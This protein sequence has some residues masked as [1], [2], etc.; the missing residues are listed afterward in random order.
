MLLTN[1]VVI[2]ERSM[3]PSASVVGARRD[4]EDYRDKQ[5]PPDADA[6]RKELR[7]GDIITALKPRRRLKSTG[8]TPARRSVDLLVEY[9]CSRTMPPSGPSR[10]HHGRRPR[11]T[12]GAAPQCGNHVRRSGSRQ[13]HRAALLPSIRQSRQRSGYRTSPTALNSSDRR[14]PALRAIKRRAH[15]ARHRRS[16]PEAALTSQTPSRLNPD[17]RGG[18]AVQTLDVAQQ[19]RRLAPSKGAPPSQ[20]DA[21]V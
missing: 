16:W 12:A 3:M 19:N 7:R 11:Q 10:T 4:L 6:W 1:P 9:R 20:H 18:S 2:S 13:R 8:N 21:R 14:R 5:I 15:F 17:A